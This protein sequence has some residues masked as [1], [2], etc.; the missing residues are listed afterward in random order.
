MPGQRGQ[1]RVY[2]NAGNSTTVSRTVYLSGAAPTATA[3]LSPTPPVRERRVLLGGDACRSP[4]R[5]GPARGH[6]PIVARHLADAAVRLPVRQRHRATCTSNPCTVPASH[7]RPPWP[8]ATTRSTT[9][10]STW[11][12]RGSSTTRTS[13]R[14]RRCR[15]DLQARPGTRRSS[16]SRSCPADR[17]VDGNMRAR[18][19]VRGRVG[20]RKF[21]GSGVGLRQYKIGAGPWTTF[22]GLNP[23]TV[24]DS[25]SLGVEVCARAI[26][27][28]ATSRTVLQDGLFIDSTAPA[29]T[30]TRVAAA[31]PPPGGTGSATPTFTAGGYND[32]G[33]VGAI[34]D[35]FRVR[36]DNIG[37]SDCDPTCA[38][39]P[40][41][42]HGPPPRA[43]VG[44]RSASGTGRTRRR[45]ERARRRAGAETGAPWWRRPTPKG[46]NGWWTSRA[47]GDH[48]R[49]RPGPPVGHR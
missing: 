12:G 45:I 5:R 8:T 34:E 24:P 3:T 15:A 16:P 48:R 9:R 35:H 19:A 40:T 11:P 1:I 17:L 20:G 10:P 7:G 43:R 49:L 38:I 28:A 36:Y 26:D 27:L 30:F 37:F 29:L 25:P 13:P 2:D 21:G 47:V 41:L 42:R 44:D 46:A 18:S 4:T 23:P 22:S 33:G 31:R 6:R 39:A 32:G 14:S